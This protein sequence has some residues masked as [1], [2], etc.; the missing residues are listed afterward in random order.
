VLFRGKRWRQLKQ[1]SAELA[2]LTQYFCGQQHFIDG[3][4]LEFRRKFYLF[5]V[6]R[7]AHGAQFRG[8]LF[9]N[10]CVPR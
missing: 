1:Q 2:L 5:I 7:T 3:C 10:G 4:R 6:A 9:S 8:K